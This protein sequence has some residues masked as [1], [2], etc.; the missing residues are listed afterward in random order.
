[1]EKK[2]RYYAQFY[3]IY[4]NMRQVYIISDLHIGGAASPD[5]RQRGFRLC[6][7]TD[8]LAN[9]INS[10]AVSDE[11]TE[12]VIN[13]DMVD[14]LAEEPF[15]VFTES[16]R[17]ASAK[18]LRIIN[19]EQAFFDALRHFLRQGHSLTILT[20]NHDIELTLPE[21]RQLFERTIAAQG[22]KYR[23]ITDGEAYT[24]GKEVIIEHGDQYDAWNKIDHSGLLLLRKMQKLINDELRHV[25][26]EEDLK[27]FNRATPEL[28]KPAEMTETQ[29]RG[30]FD[31]YTWASGLLSLLTQKDDKNIKKRLPALLKALRV[32]QNDRSFDVSQESLREYETAAR[33]LVGNGY[34]Y[35][36]MGHTHFA[37]RIPLNDAGAIYFNCGTWADLMRFPKAI[38][39]GNDQDAL[40]QLNVFI[41]QLLQNQLQEHLVFLPTYVHI[42]L[43]DNEMVSD[44]AL[45]EYEG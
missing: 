19:R 25:L 42:N 13:G 21:V 14:F 27:A 23:F 44:I 26:S 36:I 35:V 17:A 39:S 43:D 5:P 18:L 20:G 8:I 37:R 16:Q 11:A 34:K 38:F 32:L 45:M 40:A 22:K 41:D 6:T 1:M 10:L 9:F 30:W 15:E 3:P 12:L 24:I 2:Y 7:H 29:D 31:T 28:E 33:H 4:P